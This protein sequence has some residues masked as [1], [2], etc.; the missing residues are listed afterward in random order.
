[1]NV[2]YHNQE[3]SGGYPL[4]VGDRYHSQDIFRDLRYH[5][6]YLGELMKRIYGKSNI[7]IKGLIVT[8]GTGHTINITAGS[9]V[10]DFDI[11]VPDSWSG[12]PP[13]TKTETIPIM[14]DVSAYTNQAITS[15]VTD[16]VTTNYVKIAYFE[17]KGSSRSRA[18]AVGSYNSE[19]TASHVLTVDD[20]APTSNEIAITKFTSDGAT[21][22]FTDKKMSIRRAATKNTSFVLASS[23]SSEIDRLSSDIVI[24]TTTDTGFIINEIFSYI[25]SKVSIN[26]KQGTFNFDTS[27]NVV[28]NCHI[29]GKGQATILHANSSID[30]FLIVDINDV[31]IQSLY[32]NSGRFCIHVNNTSA[33]YGYHYINNIFGS[34]A[35]TQLIRFIYCADSTI[36]DCMNNG[37][38]ILINNSTK[39]RISNNQFEA[40]S[41]LFCSHCI[42]NGN[43]IGQGNNT[44]KI[45]LSYSTDLI[46]SNNNIEAIGTF[47]SG[48]FIQDSNRNTI[49]GN[50]IYTTGSNLYGIILDASDDNSI[51]GNIAFGSTAG[52]ILDAASDYNTVIGNITGSG[53]TTSITDSGTGNVV[54]NNE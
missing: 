5:Q 39:I 24:D 2:K 14:T 33:I 47:D 37:A 51:I 40:I 9:A 22:T 53:A 25:T 42:L 48:I 15:A 35:M 36:K 4:A 28:E 38:E 45:F 44:S 13:T 54:A 21:L 41:F 6:E 20:T 23:D 19:I 50:S 26:F 12:I 49:I 31:T 34:N 18:K 3:Y 43:Q 10:I 8:Q 32:F 16:G 11:T 30:I 52:I 27:V 46:I 17:S 7:I 29:S 1:M